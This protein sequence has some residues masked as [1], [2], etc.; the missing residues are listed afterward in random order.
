MQKHPG[1]LVTIGLA[2]AGVLL[3]AQTRSQS[4]SNFVPVQTIVNCR[5]S[6][7]S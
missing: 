7:R 1:L 2:T 3:F 5:S 6:T 4:D